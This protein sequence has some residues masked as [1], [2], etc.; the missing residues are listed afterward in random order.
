MKKGSIIA[1]TLAVIILI[2]ATLDLIYSLVKFED[3]R[4]VHPCLR[5]SFSPLFCQLHLAR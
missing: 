4:I 5:E 1:W 2:V 3:L